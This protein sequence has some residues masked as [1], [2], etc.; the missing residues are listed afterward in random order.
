VQANLKRYRAAVLKAA[1]EGRLV[2]TEADLAKAG[3]RKATFESGEA[4]LA[5]ILTERRQNWQ[6]RGKYKEP[7]APDTANLPSLPKA[8]TWATPD[9]LSAFDEGAICAGPFGTIFK[10]RD[11]RPEGVP[12]IFLRHVAPGHYLTHKPGFM[13]VDKWE[14][15]F[16]P[17]SVFGGELLVTK[18]GE[19]PGVCA[20]YP[21]GIGP[22]MVTPD[23]IKMTPNASVALP[24]FLMHYFN[25]QTARDFAT[26]VAFGTTRLRLTLPIFREMP[27]PLPP[28]AEQTRIMAEVER[29]LSVVEELES[30][31]T[32]NLQ[33]AT[34]LRQSI[35]QKAFTGELV[36]QSVVLPTNVIELPKAEHNRRPNTH[37]AR[38]LL[39][40]EIV[41][42]LHREPTFGR[43]KHQKI[44]HLCEHIAQIEEIH[45]QYHREAA[46]PLDNKLIYANEAELKKQKWYQEVHRESYGHAY[47]PLAKAGNHRKYVEG[48]WPDKLPLIE[49]LIELMRDWNTDRCE[50]F[51]TT[52]AAWNDLVIW[53]KEPTEVA[54]LR[55]ILERWHDNKKRFPEDR[56]CK[57]I[58]W[59]RKEGF[60]PTGFGKPTKVM[61]RK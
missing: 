49:K 48:Y 24:Q 36:V 61:E 4:L 32:V 51:C 45:G 19:P 44:F 37:F 58:R 29:R 7:A 30:V 43:I 21:E 23:V 22:A 54:I 42:R 12:I 53:G 5:R 41:H 35:L 56:W 6:G 18:L 8:W 3:N 34:R 60:V 46:G 38:A 25:S 52:Y 33:R 31:V 28:L 9:Q 17:Y 10:A 11:F 20:I 27:V 15:L 2:P 47:E 16:K 39:S 1:C 57:A 40:A 26:G 55:E 13:D 50:I 59:I 14:E